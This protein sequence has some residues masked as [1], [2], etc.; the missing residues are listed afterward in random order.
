MPTILPIQGTFDKAIPDNFGN[1][2]YRTERKLLIAIDA[3]IG[4]CGLENPVI[5]YFLDVAS[6]DKYISVFGTDKP[7]RLCK[8]MTSLTRCAREISDSFV[9]V[10]KIMSSGMLRLA[11]VRPKRECGFALMRSL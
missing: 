6:V 9:N 8:A 10:S 3:I 2:E 7:A 1:A 5:A 11:A 4:Q